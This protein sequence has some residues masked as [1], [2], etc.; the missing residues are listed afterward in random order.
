MSEHKFW[1]SDLRRDPSLIGI[2]IEYA[3]NY[4][5]DFEIM[6]HAQNLV[7]TSG[8]LPPGIARTVLNCM[9][10]DPTVIPP[11]KPPVVDYRERQDNVISIRSHTA[12]DAN[13]VPY[14]V[15]HE[16]Q[17]PPKRK[18]EPDLEHYWR[19]SSVRTSVK[20]K[21]PYVMSGLRGIRKKVLHRVAPSHHRESWCEWRLDY[22]KQRYLE[23]YKR[24]D[25]IK[26]LPRDRIILHVAMVCKPD[27]MAD[28]ILLDHKP[29]DITYCRSGC[30]KRLCYSCRKH[31][32]LPENASPETPITHCE[33]CGREFS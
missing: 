12:Y 18:P 29:E 26:Q 6:V 22:E 1:E 30:F 20:I 2:A 23:R 5:G 24:W 11:R 13:H 27:M 32:Q 25:E 14:E 8:T 21:A 31:T 3:R 7:R 10:T 4:T 9:R 17:I 16:P 28:P 33:H 15:E 19:P